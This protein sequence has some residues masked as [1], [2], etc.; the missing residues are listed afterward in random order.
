[1]HLAQ[2]ALPVRPSERR[3]TR[4]LARAA[5]TQPCRCWLRRLTVLPMDYGEP[6]VAPST[7]F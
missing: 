6:L 4:W 5:G 2:A 1:M 3:R 7:A